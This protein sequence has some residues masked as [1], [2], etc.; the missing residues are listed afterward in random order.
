[1]G[2]FLRLY[3]GITPEIVE[4]GLAGAA[5]RRRTLSSSPSACACPIQPR[6]NR[7]VV[8]AIIEA[9]KPAHTGYTL[10]IVAG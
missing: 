3:T 5:P 1:L 7:A 4:L 6:W 10:E 8:E 2:E 9:E